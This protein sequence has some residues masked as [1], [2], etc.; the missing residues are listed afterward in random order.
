MPNSQSI[1][2]YPVLLFEAFERTRQED[3]VVLQCL[4]PS[5]AKNLRSLCYTLRQLLRKSPVDW[6]QA[7]ALT[8]AD[9][10]FYIDGSRLIIG[11]SMLTAQHS[12][13]ILPPTTD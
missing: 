1:D 9:R 5:A 2:K 11:R 10:K 4:S 13:T 8:V 3:E 6:H 7:L 12:A